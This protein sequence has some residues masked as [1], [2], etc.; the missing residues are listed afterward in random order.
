MNLQLFFNSTC[1][2]Y[3]IC[4]IEEYVYKNGKRG[5]KYKI[6][7]EQFIIIVWLQMDT[8][9]ATENNEVNSLNE[10]RKAILCRFINQLNKKF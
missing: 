3:P 5:M 8:Q 4:A 1:Q 9:N 6:L 10:K 2:K 7:Q